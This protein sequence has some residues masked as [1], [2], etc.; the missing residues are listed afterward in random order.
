VDRVRAS[1][2]MWAAG[3]Y[4]T[5]GDLLAGVARELVAE[6]GV[7]G[8][9]ALD[10]ATGTGNGAIAAARA[11]GHV[12]A[13]DLTPELLVVARRRAEAA[14]VQVR[15]VEGDMVALDLADRSYDRVLST[16]GAMFAPD[17]AAMA[18]ELVRVCRPG[19]VVAVTAWS[20]DGVF[21]RLG[22]TLS[23]FLPEAPAAAVD[24]IDWGRPARV[25][26]FFAG[27]P[28]DVTTVERTVR[29]EWSSVDALVAMLADLSGPVLSA[30]A[31]LEA[32]GSWQEALAA[33]AELFAADN[34]ADGSLVVDVP[35]LRTRAQVKGV[36]G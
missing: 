35:Y 10:V 33:M 13:L 4:G 11:G 5:V 6:V 8:L 36:S 20:P 32:N 12:T 30:R 22:P 16:F 28:V 34:K 2:A 17:P 9:D 26:E 31:A 3:D 27:L 25:V 21:G 29:V 19:G 18:G 1:R 7:R 24:P 15:W 14:G 23:R